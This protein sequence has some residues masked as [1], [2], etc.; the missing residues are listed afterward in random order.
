MRYL[1]VTGLLISLTLALTPMG[2]FRYQSTAFLFQDDYDL[3]FDPARIPLIKGSRV[4]TNLSNLVS[5]QE[6][7]FGLRTENY[8]LIGGSTDL[9]GYIYPGAVLDK[10]CSKIPLPTGLYGRNEFEPLTG[11]A[12][13]VETEWLDL[14]NNG[15]YDHRVT[16]INEQ[17]AFSDSSNIDYYFGLGLKMDDLRLGLSFSNTSNACTYTNPLYNQIYDRR[18]SSLVS[19]ALTYT[20]NDTLTGPDKYNTSVK[21]FALSSWYDLANLSI[22]IMVGFSPIARDSN[23]VHTGFRF[24][25]RSPSNP[26]IQDYFQATMKDSLRKPITGIIIPIGLSVF[27]NPKENIQSRYYLDFFTRQEK[28]G[29]DAQSVEHNTM[30]S[31]GRPGRAASDDLIWHK[32]SGGYTSKGLNLRTKQLFKVS[33]QFDLGFGFE[34][35]TWDWQDSLVDTMSFFGTYSYNNGDTISGHEDY[36]I[37][38]K[39]SEEWVDKVSGVRKVF[40][41]PVG[42]EFRLIPALSLRLGAIHSIICTDITTT[43]LLRAFEPTHTRYEYGDSTFAESVGPQSE[44]QATSETETTTDHSTFFTYGIG[45]NPT[46]N[47]QIDIKGFRNLT[48]L[49]NW[50]LSVIFKF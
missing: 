13:T 23:Y 36:R 14:D 21:R 31:T 29:S 38:T 24:E 37:I 49:T 22:G 6:E 26:A 39:R 46:K 8:F 41:I 27:A 25:N 40:S 18:D 28:L 16:Q 47:L 42:L 33:E 34:F 10:Y 44:L 20:L 1:I 45:F 4:Y 50:K 30:D 7:Q 15:S 11:D 3:L 5:N 19:G 12:K 2:S 9:I 32:Y 17:K 48:D 35:G 43:G